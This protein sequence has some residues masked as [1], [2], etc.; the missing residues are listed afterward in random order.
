M[1]NVDNKLR[2]TYG[3]VD[4]V[5]VIKTIGLQ[6]SHFVTNW[7]T[8]KPLNGGEDMGNCCRASPLPRENNLTVPRV[9][10]K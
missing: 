6:N 2:H 3:T 4:S 8:V 7:G 10:M 5:S 1:S 9:A